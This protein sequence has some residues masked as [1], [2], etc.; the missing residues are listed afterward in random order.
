[1]ERVAATSG[2]TS[3]GAINHLPLAGD[4]WT[5]RYLVEGRP[6]PSPGREPGAAYR[7]VSAAYFETM[8]QRLVEGRFF[9]LDD[10]S[11]S[12][13]A[14]I[15]NQTLARRW[16]PDGRATGHRIRFAS[17]HDGDPPR[18]IVG[19]VADAR[20]QDLVSAPIDEAYIPLTQRPETDPGRSSI[21]LVA[22]GPDAPSA[23]LQA[24]QEAV[25]HGDPQAAV[26]EAATLDEVLDREVWREHLAANLVGAFAAVALV[27]SM[28]GIHG[29]VSH[30][31]S[32]RV[33]EFG[34]RVALG[35]APG[36]L[37]RLAMREALLPVVFGLAVGVA[38]ALAAGRMMTSVLVGVDPADPSVLWGTV[39]VLAI[40]AGVA[41]W[42]P[43]ARTARL[44]PSVA[45]RTE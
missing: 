39:G 42:R 2:V 25:W 11:D 7:V 32:T 10:R 29:I 37:P 8:S 3:I 26:F 9:S 24:L 28:L 33:R 19:V 15:V 40:A 6:T 12:V 30:G 23:L 1:L 16:F 5:F 14:V 17:Q 44:D 13:P 41:A 27:L 36:S 35:A 22:R 31:V 34:V 38:L 20:E 4:L 21:T 45:L 18:T 43:A